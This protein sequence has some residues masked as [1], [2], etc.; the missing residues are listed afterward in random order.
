[1]KLALLLSAGLATLALSGH[2]AFPVVH[3]EPVR[4]A[5]KAASKAAAL[6]APAHEDQPESTVRLL[7]LAQEKALNLQRASAGVADDTKLL[8]IGLARDARHEAE[9]AAPFR[10]NWITL[11]DGGQVARFSLQSPGARALRLGLALDGMPEEAQLRVRGAQDPRNVVL[12]TRGREMREAA[13]RQGVYWTPVTEGDR[14]VAEL[15]LPRGIAASSL[16]VRIE[17]AS[18][19]VAS[20]GDKF[21]K[22][23]GVGASQS[24]QLDVACVSHPTEAF[25]NASRSVARM[26]YTTN[27]ASYLCT[28]TLVNG[29][30]PGSQVPFLHTASHCINSEAAASSLNTFWFFEATYCGGKSAG[31]YAQLSGGATLLYSNVATDGALLRLNDR[32]PEGAYFSGWDANPVER[33]M[34]AITLHHPAGDVKKASSG[35]VLDITFADPSAGSF[36]AV[37]WLSGSTEPGSS[38]AGL[39]VLKDGEYFLRGGLQ[40]GS[41]AC[42]NS[43]NSA[44]PANRDYFSRFDADYGSVKSLLGAAAAPIEDYT[45]AWWNPKESGWGITIVQHPSDQVFVTWYTY[46]VDGRGMWLVMPSGSWTGASELRGTLYQTNGPGYQQPFDPARVSLRVV[47]EAAFSFRDASNATFSYTLNGIAGSKPITRLRF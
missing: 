4:S 2:A 36:A 41:A 3:G 28:G 32:A 7:P 40:G 18:H 21:A 39:F 20:P 34:A 5:T 26:V 47:G 15:Y 42:A 10:L 24:C 1:M 17:S 35:Q 19:L 13:L 37:A 33:G 44:T 30:N 46:D 43:G 27:G 11:A 12:V 16:R 25:A 9:S 23:G 14:Q 22:A 6:L 29:A 45:D 31:N 38:G 8:Q